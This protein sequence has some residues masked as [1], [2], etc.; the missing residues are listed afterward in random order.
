[1]VIFSFILL[2]RDIT[3]KVSIDRIQEVDQLDW[4]DMWR[5]YLLIDNLAIQ[6]IKSSGYM[7]KGL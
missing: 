7:H 2:L 5:I 1:M 6:V 4:I 3:T